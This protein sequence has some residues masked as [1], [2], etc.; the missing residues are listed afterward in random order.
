MWTAEP[1]LVARKEA[2]FAVMGVL[3]LF[4]VLMYL[5]K[6]KLWSRVEH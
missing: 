6:Q 4:A 2:G 5:V 3:F 1:H